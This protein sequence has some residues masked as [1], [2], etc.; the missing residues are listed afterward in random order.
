MSTNIPQ[1]AINDIGDEQAFLE[2]VDKTI[3]VWDMSS[4]IKTLEVNDDDVQT[5][6]SCIATFVGH[7]DYVL[8][9]SCSP[10]GDWIAS[11][12]KDRCV[13]FWDPKTNQTQL[14]LQGHKNSG[15]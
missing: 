4:T 5:P 10:Q 11:G 13:Q 15:A 6:S 1:V 14:V 2:A 7:K 8:S 9:V 3:K 12:S